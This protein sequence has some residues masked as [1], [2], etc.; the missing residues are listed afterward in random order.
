MPYE[1]IIERPIENRIENRYYVD[2]EVEVPIT[3]VTEVEVEVIKEVKKYVP[4]ERKIEIETVYEKP[5]ERIIEVPIEIIR[6]IPVAV[7]RIVNK[8]QERTILRPH[9]SEIVERAVYVDKEVKVDKIVEKFI[10]VDVPVYVDKIIERVVNVPEYIYRDV[11]VDVSKFVDVNKD[12]FYDRIVERPRERIVEKEIVVDRIVERPYTVERVVDRTRQVPV[13]RIVEVPV[14]VDKIVEVPVEKRVE[15]PYTVQ[16][17]V[18]KIVP[19]QIN[20][21]IISTKDVEVPYERIIEEP[22]EVIEEI[23]VPYERVVEKIVEV[24]VYK[25]NLVYDYIE[26]EVPVERIVE[27]P[28]YH[29]IEVEVEIIREKFVEV[30]IERIIEKIVEI[31]KIIEKPIYNQ[32]IVEKQIQKIVERRI[33]VPIEKYVEIPRYREVAKHIR[34]EKKVQRS[35]VVEK[36]NTRSMRKSVKTST[37]SAS[38][39]NAYTSLGEGLSKY[40]IENLKLGLDIKSLQVQIVDYK[41]ISK[42]PD[43]TKRENEDMRVK[44]STL[45]SSLTNIRSENVHLEQNTMTTKETQIVE[46]YSQADVNKLEQEVRLLIEKNRKLADILT[47]LGQPVKLTNTAY[48]QHSFD[49]GSKITKSVSN[50]YAQGQT[51]YVTSQQ[52]AKTTGYSYGN[53]TYQ[54]QTT[55]GLLV[56]QEHNQA[57]WETQQRLAQEKASQDAQRVQQ[58][59]KEENDAILRHEQQVQNQLG[60]NQQQAELKTQTQQ[61]R[62]E[63]GNSERNVVFEQI[64]MHTVY[65]SSYENAQPLSAYPQGPR[66]SQTTTIVGEAQVRNSSSQRSNVY[67]TQAPAQYVTIG[68]SG[69]GSKLISG[70]QGR[71]VQGQDLQTSTVISTPTGTKTIEPVRYVAS[72][73]IIQGG[74]R[75]SLFD[76]VRSSNYL[77]G[78][79]DISGR[80]VVTDATTSQGYKDVQGNY[81][82][83]PY[84]NAYVDSTKKY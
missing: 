16:R 68:Q 52:G 81:S 6:E 20:V 17:H 31:E 30:P 21:P 12:V 23:Q 32:K 49:E 54:G 79:Q 22:Y 5:Y 4:I 27:V 45:E 51:T 41:K 19:R 56:S 62:T 25:E 43:W 33:E 64:P 39:K 70:S 65:S 63:K 78:Q 3:H 11:Y 10:D 8:N 18:K 48:I 15:V 59:I 14:Y 82:S 75:G 57:Q 61:I 55:S 44:I 36:K 29:D 9:R 53:S 80:V 60:Y 40:K 84:L 35:V 67:T 58:Q 77:S 74:N 76:Q 47:S 72:N 50:T 38:Q 37:I 13:E 24:P 83:N 28:V 69:L 26:I 34:V 42:N 46:A 2:K 66:K 7:E 1:V 71:Y 73:R